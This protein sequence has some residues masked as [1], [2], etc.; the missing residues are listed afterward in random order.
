MLLLFPTPFETQAELGN[1]IN[2]EIEMHRAISKPDVTPFIGPF[3][4]VTYDMS[5]DA[6][7]HFIGSAD[8]TQ[9]R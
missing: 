3:Y 5:I 9:S 4:G 1:L 6:G 7:E 2:L 8:A